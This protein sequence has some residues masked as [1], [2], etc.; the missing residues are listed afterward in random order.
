MAIVGMH[1]SGTSMVA[2]ILS[3]AGLYLGS[4]DVLY[5]GTSDNPNGYW[6]HIGFHRVNESVLAELGGGWDN[7]PAVPERWR[8]DSRLRHFTDEAERLVGEFDGKDPWGWK[9]PRTSLTLSLWIDLIP[10]LRVLVCV[11]NPLEVA[12]SLNRRGMFSYSTGLAL[13][14]TYNERILDASSAENLIVTDYSAYFPEPTAELRRVLS[15]LDFTVPPQKLEAA[16]AVHRGS[17]RH[18]RYD[19]QDLS[20]ARVAPDIVEFYTWLRAQ[21][22]ERKASAR[23]PRPST[24]AGPPGR[25]VDERAVEADLTRRHVR[26]LEEE[27][28][29]LH[30]LATSRGEELSQAQA[31]EAELVREIGLLRERVEGQERVIERMSDLH[32]SFYM[33]ETAV[34]ESSPGGAETYARQLRW[35]KEVVRRETPVGAAL[36]VVSRGDE[37]LA[38]LYGRRVLHFPQTGDGIPAGRHPASGLAAIAHLEAVRA[39]GAD[40]FLLPALELWWL[41]HYPEL[42][43]HLSGRYREVA[44]ES[45]ACLL[46]ALNGPL[47]ARTR[48]RRDALELA[49]AV[50][51]EVGRAPSVLDWDSGIGLADALPG[52]SILAETPE[53]G[54]PYPDG[55]VDVVALA[56]PAPGASAEA[57]RVASAAVIA[58]PVDADGDGAVQLRLKELP[59]SALELR[60]VAIVVTCPGGGP[61]AESCLAALDETLPREFGGEILLVEG[62]PTGATADALR[63]FAEGRER[64]TV[65]ERPTAGGP[66]EAANLGAKAASEDTLVF[67]GDGTLPLPGWLRPLLEALRDQPHAGAVGGRLVFPDGSLFEAGGAV[68]SDGSALRFGHGE[69]NP[70]GALF[71]HVR[72]VDYCSRLLLATPRRLF[73]EL[74]GFHERYAADVFADVD[75]CLSL[76]RRGTHVYFQPLSSAVRLVAGDT[77]GSARGRVQEP[78]PSFVKRWRPTLEDQPGRP[79]AFDIDALHALAAGR[80]EF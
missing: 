36:A 35:I 68:F 25:L 48:G 65:V 31:R 77:D 57:E 1:R 30:E 55:S 50:R 3:E 74:G 29:R 53:N 67:L 26:A 70:E 60:G 47:D 41:D 49:D 76:R 73:L 66:L 4:P 2:H 22:G 62:A 54:L 80:A 61:E 24:A 56:Q 27:V 17:L 5:P 16:A 15:L 23:A 10:D 75:Y 78:D 28:G 59:M 11:R 58:F 64:A 63:R 38:G 43:R 19:V 52:T 14:R 6:E 34:V 79:E 37:R 13:W 44:R 45:G 32:E 12:L 9:D 8:D 69:P 20:E 46:F 18:G 39:R 42:R 40:Y 33:L 72:K 21:A 71:D 7:P 51:V